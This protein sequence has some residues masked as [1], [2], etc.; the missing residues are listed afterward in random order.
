MDLGGVDVSAKVDV[1]QA[2]AMKVVKDQLKSQA[3]MAA[4]LTQPTLVYDA[5]GGV[6]AAPPQTSFDVQM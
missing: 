6:H 1:S 4:A 5:N 3:Q 2:I